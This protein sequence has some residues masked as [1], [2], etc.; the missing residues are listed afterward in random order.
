[1]DYQIILNSTMIR[2]SDLARKMW[3]GVKSAEKKLLH[4]IACREG[5]RLT[6]QDQELIVAVFKREY[7]L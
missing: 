4:K 2:K 7:G 1:M 3:P 6:E 5:Q